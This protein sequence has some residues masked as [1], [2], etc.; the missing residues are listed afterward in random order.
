[1]LPVFLTAQ[2]DLRL[3]FHSLNTENGLSQATNENA[4]LDSRGL[5]WLSSL[6]GLNRFDGQ[7]VRVYKSVPDD[8]TSLLDNIVTSKVFEDRLGNLWFTTYEGLHCYLRD[9]DK[10][11]RF[12]LLNRQG[13]RQ[14]KDYKAIHLDTTGNFWLRV[15]ID[16]VGYL[17]CFNTHTLKDTI[18]CGI[19]GHRNFP[20]VDESGQLI[21]VASSQ[22]NSKRG[23]ELIEITSPNQTQAFFNRGNVE[24]EECVVYD[25]EAI[26][27]TNWYLGTNKGLLFFNPDQLYLDAFTSYSDQPIGRVNSCLNLNETTLLVASQRQGV[28]IFDKLQQRFTGSIPYEP[29]RQYGLNIR[30]V[31][32]MYLDFHDQL[33]LSSYTDGVAYAHL[34]KR[35]FKLDARFLDRDV[36]ALFESNDGDVFCTYGPAQ[37]AYFPDG[38]NEYLLVSIASYE[39]EEIPSISHYYEHESSGI[40]GMSADKM[41]RWDSVGQRFEYFT[42]LPAQI[43]GLYQ[44]ADGEVLISTFKGVFAI[45][46]TENGEVEFSP[47]TALESYQTAYFKQLYE[48]QNGL[49]YLAHDGIELL[50]FDCNSFPC[51]QVEKIEGVGYIT[52]LIP[53]DS[54]LW[55]T[56]SSGLTRFNTLDRSH[57]ILTEEDGIPNDYYYCALP[58]AEGQLWISG[59]QGVIRY[60]P[61]D[62]SH[63]RYTMADGLQGNEFNENGYLQTRS[64]EIWLGGTSGLNRFFPEEVEALQLAPKIAFTSLLVNDEPFTTDPQ[65]NELESISLPYRQNTLSLAFVALDFSDPARTALQYQLENHEDNWVEVSSNGFARY[66]NLPPGNYDFKVRAANSDGVW[67]ELPQVLSIHIRTP[68]WRSRWTYAAGFLLIV[69]LIYGIFTYRLQQALR[70]ERLRVK[71][72]SDLHDDVGGLLSGLAMQSEILELTAPEDQKPKLSRISELSRSAM[73]RM[74]DTVWAI[75]ARKDKLESILDRIQEHAAEI[76]DPKGIQL[77]LRSEGL[78]MTRNMN[79]QVRQNLYLICKEAMTNTAKYSNGDLMHISFAPYGR[80]GLELELW[81]N[82]KVMPKKHKSSGLGMS[83]MEMRSKQIGGHF[84]FD[85]EDGFRISVVIP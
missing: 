73:S 9:Q 32:K 72:S 76:L 75:D 77:N 60:N 57:T 33:W 66:S 84:S 11:R 15:G 54:L 74:R 78:D 50:V 81:D 37:I 10:F 58:D 30:E 21:Q 27:S 65:V 62:Q 61:G 67:N 4:F 7:N 14:R 44:K 1:M 82:G 48:D 12:Q 6:E 20:I 38:G 8:T 69:G 83:N 68:W 22:F 53:Q 17:H 3:S 51:Q 36:N 47:Y 29:D 18:I 13:E 39:G 63:H 64:G 45:E 43:M 52:G 24:Q 85:V 55:V 56:A 42:E 79:A 25:V 16:S 34:E 23:I 41:L 31:T 35:K 5:I 70:F 19:D 80:K 2:E 46:H 40:F 59:N 28:L 71:I 49:L 26:S